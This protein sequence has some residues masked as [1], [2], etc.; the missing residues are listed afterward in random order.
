M[1]TVS[2]ETAFQNSSENLLQGGSWGRLIISDFGE[3]GIHAIKHIFLQ[4]VSASPE[5]QTSP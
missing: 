1:K 3:G 2:W 4:K 5:E